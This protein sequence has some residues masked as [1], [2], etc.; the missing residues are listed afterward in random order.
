MANSPIGWHDAVL[1]AIRRSA[2]RSAT[3][4]FSRQQLIEDEMAEVRRQ[5]RTRGATPDQTLSRVLQE[6]ADE[7]LIAFLGNGSYRLLE[8]GASTPT[9]RASG[10]TDLGAQ[11]RKTLEEA[12][13]RELKGLSDKAAALRPPLR[14]PQFN[15]MLAEYGGFRTAQILLDKADTSG[16]FTKLWLHSI[17]SGNSDAMHLALEYVVLGGPWRTLFTAAQLDVARKRLVDVE[18]DLPEDTSESGGLRTIVREQD[19]APS[20]DPAGPTTGPMPSS[21]TGT[22]HRSTEGTAFVYVLRFGMRDVWK[23]GHTQDVAERLGDVSKHVPEEVLGENWH[24]YTTLWCVDHGTAYAAE[25][26]LLARLSSFRT[27]GER[28]RCSQQAV[29]EALA[30]ID[31]N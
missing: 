1:A 14:F 2:A 9:A 10:G 13:E 21:W 19:I 18:C 26:A 3:E 27:I 15:A 31:A 11:A 7:G 12:L 25:Q 20:R 30:G 22:V 4:V 24:V 8:A 29:E 16:G 23:V 17:D 6:L 28:V 5:T